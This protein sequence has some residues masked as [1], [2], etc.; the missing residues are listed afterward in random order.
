MLYR[1]LLLAAAA[2][3]L[4][5][6][7]LVACSRE[8][9]P[10]KF[11]EQGRPALLS[12]WG[13][14]IKD[15]SLLSLNQG[16]EPYEL[17]SSLFTDHA[18][19]LRTIWMP[20]GRKAKYDPE[21]TFEFP[22][23]TIISKTFYYPKEGAVRL[24]RVVDPGAD[25]ALGAHGLDLNQVRLI[26]TRLLVRREAGWV[27]FPYVWN[28]QQ[29]DAELMRTGDQLALELAKPPG[30]PE[31]FTYVVPNENQCA[32]CHMTQL[33]SKQ[34]QPI[35]P[36][37]R[38]LNRSLTYSG[39]TENQ[40]EH[41]VRVGYLEKL[42]AKVDQLPMAVNWRDD[43]QPLDQRAR[44]YLDINCAHCH[45]PRGPANN[46]SL[47]LEPFPPLGLRQGLCKPSVAAGKG[48]GDRLFGIVPGNPDE[49]ILPFRMA[50][51]EGGVMMPE[52]GRSIVHEEGVELIR[53]WIEGLPGH[54]EPIQQPGR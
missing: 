35:G 45:N 31:Q 12:E 33:K 51:K 26:E 2:A 1:R 15:G 8:P 41:L 50:S 6:L 9:D 47:N 43:K 10:V 23:G 54:C 5:A 52:L 42:P 53:K 13:L 19:K 44:A 28:D 30:K 7:G 18:H 48:T 24:Q 49:S 27:A 38:H 36:K 39:K 40:L 4:C 20:V 21:A 29:T 34:L 17:N 11:I 16:V 22:V 32:S 37:A 46:T 25:K 3:L 14:L